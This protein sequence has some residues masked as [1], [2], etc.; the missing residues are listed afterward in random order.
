MR[1]GAVR[2]YNFDP[3]S[4]IEEYADPST[5]RGGDAKANAVI[6]RAVL[7]GERG[8]RRDIV[9]LNAAAGLIAGGKAVDFVD[10]FA[11]AGRSI[12]SGNALK[13]L[14]GLAAGTQ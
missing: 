4:V 13:A 11:L 7:E 6:T 12:D 1:D 8:P 3:L 14:E 10:G 9:C 2:T 5:L